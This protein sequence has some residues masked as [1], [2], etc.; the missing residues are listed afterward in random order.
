[1]ENDLK[2]AVFVALA[3]T[4][5]GA[6]SRGRRVS[7]QSWERQ[8]TDPFLGI[9][10]DRSPAN[11]WLLVPRD[12]HQRSD[13]Q[14]CQVANLH[15][16]ASG[17]VVTGY[18]SNRKLIQSAGRMGRDPSS[19]RVCTRSSDSRALGRRHLERR[20]RADWGTQP[21]NAPGRSSPGAR[22]P[23]PAP[24]H[25][26]AVGSA[27]RRRGGSRSGTDPHLRTHVL[28]H[29]LCGCLS[30]LPEVAPRDAVRIWHSELLARDP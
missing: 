25:S 21:L 11:I 7:S 10:K 2:D 27:W 28:L 15:F 30:A 4:E 23:G 3:M 1:M 22:R 9:H 18:R 5:V 16:S 29:A 8:E 14:T 26:A 20:P 13:L 19:T 17:F 6:A 12:P 24:Q